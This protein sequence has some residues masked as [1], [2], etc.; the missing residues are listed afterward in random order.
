MFNQYI[1]E[2]RLKK[3]LTLRDFCLQMKLDPSNWSKVERG[4]NPPPKDV[5]LLKKLADFFSL[6]QAEELELMDKAALERWEI[7]P[8]LAQNEV[9]MKN[10]MPAFFRIAREKDFSNQD[11]QEFVAGIKKIHSRDQ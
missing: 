6:N 2:L 1:K 5:V 11:V 3:R 7:P 9:L 4:I 8:D 10:A